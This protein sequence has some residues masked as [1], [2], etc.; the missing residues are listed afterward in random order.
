M[1]LIVS[2]HLWS[3]LTAWHS[4]N[5]SAILSHITGTALTTK[6]DTST[7]KFP[8]DIKKADEEFHLAGGLFLLIGADV[9]YKM[10]RS[11]RRARPGNYNVL[12]VTD[13]VS[14]PL[15]RTPAINIQND[16]QL[17]NWLS[18]QSI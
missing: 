4:T 3:R 16:T 8:K 2:I 11:G 17:K 7:W 10:L 5:T 12:Q 6:L 18:Q 14:K 1:Y 15:G 13:L 9:F